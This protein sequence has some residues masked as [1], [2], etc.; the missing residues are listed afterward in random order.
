MTGQFSGPPLEKL[1]AAG[2]NIGAVIVPAPQPAGESLP[3]RVEPMPQPATGLPLIN[4]HGER[5]IIHLAWS[6]SI[7]VWEV[8]SLTDRRTHTLLAGLQPDLI[9]VACFPYI[10]PPELLQLPTYGCLNLHPSLLPAY[11]GP[12]PLF[13]IARNDER[14]TGVT[15]HLLDEKVDSGDIVAQHSFERPD[16]ISGVELEQRCAQVGADLLLAAVRQLEQGRPLTRRQQLEAEATYQPWPCEDDFIIPIDW[17][18]RRA[19]NFLRGAE[20]WPLVIEVGEAQFAIQAALSYSVDQT[21]DKPYVLLGNELWAQFQPGV[22]RA[23]VLIPKA[24]A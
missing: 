12:A 3:Q 15:L 10:F 20:A 9:V 11:R 18:A 17:S 1:L 16:G 14:T 4:P 2:V 5:N 7:P 21:L 6:R 8:G 19:F 23:R 22:L 24:D 13:W